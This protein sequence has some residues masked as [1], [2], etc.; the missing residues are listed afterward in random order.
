[1]L[2]GPRL[3]RAAEV[4]G[5]PA[6][7][8]TALSDRVVND[9]AEGKPLVVQVHAPLCDATIIPCGNARLGD[10]DN[11]DTNL[12]WSTTPGFGK[13][14][15]RRGG[16]WKRVMERRGAETGDD[17][18]LALLVY[19]RTMTAPAAWRTKGA[20]RRFEVYVVICG[21]RGRA[22]DRALA[23]YARELSGGGE[24]V[25]A[26]PEPATD[27]LR[28]GGAAHLVAYSG[29]NRLMDVGA[30]E[31][32]APG[33]QAIG[34]IA[35]ACLTA[36]YMAQNVPAPT[37]VPLLMTRDFLFANAAPVEA[38]VLAFARGGG[39]RELRLAAAEAYA[40]VQK[41]EPK[42][43]LGAFTNPGDPRWAKAR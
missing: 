13:W 26:L 1:M 25:I 24:R 18:L 33:K 6:A 40:G 38:V 32:P 2:A 31:W 27:P 19:R 35:V 12:Y 14:F 9:L 20:P 30:Y 21:W 29:H 39:Y 11:L 3:S 43:V 4:T 36:E 5:E 17:D 16:G 10:G 34:A 42:R 28:A 15:S 23:A 41:K 37:R 8:L 22:I 7:W